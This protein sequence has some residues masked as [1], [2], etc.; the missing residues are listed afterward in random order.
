LPR[1]FCVAERRL[2]KTLKNRSGLDHDAEKRES[3]FGIMV[4]K[5]NL[6][7]CVQRQVMPLGCNM[8]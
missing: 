5:I 8:L 7:A 2:S 6:A 4:W 1:R 3:L